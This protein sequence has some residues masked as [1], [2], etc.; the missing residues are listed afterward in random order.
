MKRLEG[1]VAVVTGA[2]SGI[3]RATSEH[4][5]R[6]GC[7]VAAVDVNVE[8]AEETASR[9]RALGRRASVHVVDVADRERMRDLPAQVSAALGS[10]SVLVNNAGVTVA[11]TFED[12]QWDDLDWIV[13]V[14]FWG[15]VHGCKFFLPEL[16]RADEAHI[17]NVSSLAGLIGLPLQSSYS[18]TKFAVRGF[19]ESLAAELCATAIG[20]TAVF[21]GAIRTQILSSAR[22]AGDPSVEKMSDALSRH[23][24]SPDVV[25]ARIVRAIQH[26]EFD[27]VVGAETHLAGWA[28]RLSPA[29]LRRLLG[30]GFV[31]ARSRLA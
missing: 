17:V 11:R 30:W 7:H 13:G 6:H 5:A 8:S 25:A 28:T 29:V 26:D 31:K 27:V 21:P 19:T 15:V 4:L 3:G 2:G 24:P 10:T 22:H 16:R 20:V 23:A 9:V 1:R 14:N 18:A 12:H